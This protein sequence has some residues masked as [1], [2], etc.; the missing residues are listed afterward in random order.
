M[1]AKR[2]KRE[3]SITDFAFCDVEFFVCPTDFAWA[4]IHTHEDHAFEGPYFIR[5]DWLA[6]GS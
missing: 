4:M 5:A 2:Q 6:G 1:I 3:S